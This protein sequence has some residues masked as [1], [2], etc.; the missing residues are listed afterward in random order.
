MSADEM[1][2]PVTGPQADPQALAY[3]EDWAEEPEHELSRRP[4]HR[5]LAPI[6][7]ALLVTLLT[8]CG[9]IA[10]V[11]VEKGESGSSSS[12]SGSLGSLASR[13]GSR[14]VGAAA[15]S[16]SGAPAGGSNVTVGEVSFLRGGTVYVKDS[17]GN[18]IKVT[19]SAGSKVTKT[20]TTKVDDIHPGETVIVAGAK[21]GDGSVTA[22][23]ITIGG[24]TRGLLG[25]NVLGSTGSRSSSAGSAGASSSGGSSGGEPA[26]F[27]N[28]GG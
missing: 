18:T 27:G 3:E 13:L 20:V 19:T 21:N 24:S 8:A 10:G 15:R 4:R 22:S 12:S 6:P 1:A 7:V 25:G 11:E 5:L 16:T 26:L 28:G 9:F 14:G 17:E 23:S 2:T